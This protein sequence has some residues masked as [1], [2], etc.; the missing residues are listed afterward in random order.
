MQNY[1]NE[2]KIAHPYIE[3]FRNSIVNFT[4]V[5]LN[6]FFDQW[7]ETDKVIDYEIEKVKRI[8]K[9]GDYEITLEREGRMQM[10]I[11]L[12]IT[13]IKDSI[14][15]IHIPNDWFVKKTDAKVLPKWFGWDNLNENYTF[16]LNSKNRIK[17]VQ[18]DTSG[19]LA[20]IDRT[21]NYYHNKV[22]WSFDHRLNNPNDWEHKTVF[23]RP[24]VWYNQ[25]EGIKIGLHLNGS[26]VNQIDNFEFTAWVNRFT[27]NTR[28]FDLDSSNSKLVN[29]LKF[30]NR[31]SYNFTYQTPLNNI[32]PKLSTT[33]QVR[34]LDGVELYKWMFERKIENQ[35]YTIQLFAKSMRFYELSFA[36][37]PKYLQSGKWNNYIGLNIINNYSYSFGT[38]Q[39]TIAARS[40]SFLSDYNYQAL[41]LTS[42]NKN[43]LG[44]FDLSTRFFAQLG[45]GNF[46]GESSLYATGANTEEMLENK[47]VR[48]AAFYPSSWNN[49]GDVTNHFQFGGGLNLR[50]YNGY[51]LPVTD[52]KGNQIFLT[53]SNSGASVNAE[54]GFDRFFKVRIRR[55]S[56]W[57][58]M[59][60]YAFADA[61][62]LLPNN[63]VFN[64][65]KL[66]PLRFDA[67]LGATLTIKK[68]WVLEK[69]TP[70]TL[71]FDMPLFLNTPPYAE[72]QYF[73]FRWLISVERAF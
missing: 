43:R 6:W 67:G 10:P 60:T 30:A 62:V 71:R 50:G 48:S 29:N 57:L 49:I 14:F 47:Y 27:F 20:D 34:F 65:T 21:N 37:Q 69:T 58:K 12:T 7:F 45:K 56:N 15:N 52:S 4:H 66:N 70:L 18:I 73:K 5:D 9:N 36:N 51:L 46:A 26:Y 11:D 35:K 42:I 59:N 22:I 39:I 32:M 63:G 31:F 23:W 54:L 24:D 2:Y 41:S 8:N 28:R 19:R 55:L 72:G 17:Q 38:G 3:D 53:N 33:M 1:F 68:W 25:F 44:K 61:G 40:T 13:T 64:D 16:N